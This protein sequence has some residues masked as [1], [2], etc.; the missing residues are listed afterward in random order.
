MYECWREDPSDRPT[1]AELIRALVALQNYQPSTLRKIDTVST[2]TRCFQIFSNDTMELM[3]LETQQE[4]KP[5]EEVVMR[6][7]QRNLDEDEEK[8]SSV[9]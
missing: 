6:K 1:F 8:R 2:G 3:D 5:G 9:V 4:L 7:N